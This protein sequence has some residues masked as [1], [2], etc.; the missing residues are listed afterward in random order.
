MLKTLVLSE[1]FSNANLIFK[2]RFLLKNIVAPRGSQ[3][4]YHVFFLCLIS[5][6]KPLKTEWTQMIPEYNFSLLEVFDLQYQ[7][8]RNTDPRK[9]PYLLNFFTESNNV[10]LLTCLSSVDDRQKRPRR[11]HIHCINLVRERR[12]VG[13]ARKRWR[14]FVGRMRAL[15]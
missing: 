1:N 14:N 13:A 8:F 4:G 2:T 11:S 10:M 15:P 5:H 3:C 9:R 6:Q 7:G 12:K